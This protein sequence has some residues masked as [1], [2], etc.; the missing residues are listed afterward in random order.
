MGICARFQYNPN[1][2][3]LNVV[4]RILRYLISTTNLGL[5]YEKGTA[6]NITSYY[7]VDFAG[8]KVERKSTSSC[9]CFLGKSLI[10]WSR[11]KQ[12]IITLSTAEIE[13]VSAANCCGQILWIKHQSEDF[14]LRYI[15][16]SILCDNTSAINLA[17]NPI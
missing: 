13:Y 15:K 16:I 5:W 14:N 4:K 17:K 8:D 12:N 2:S 11:N 10:T 7:D 6:C 3:H 1:Q 9:C